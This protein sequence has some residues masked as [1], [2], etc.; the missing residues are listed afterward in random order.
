M[1]FGRRTL[2][3]GVR[4]VR[5][6]PNAPGRTAGDFFATHDAGFGNSLFSREKQRIAKLRLSLRPPP[7]AAFGA[8]M[9]TGTVAAPVTV[10][11]GVGAL[12]VRA[13]PIPWGRP[14]EHPDDELSP[15]PFNRP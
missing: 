4:G 12:L 13:L 7:P 5:W 2:S 3:A 14:R 9:T 6:T 1:Q 10:P 15:A 11:A 8:Y